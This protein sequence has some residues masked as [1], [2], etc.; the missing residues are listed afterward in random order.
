M[1][2]Q[3]SKPKRLNW[4]L[5]IP[6]G[7]EYDAELLPDHPQFRNKG[8]ILHRLQNSR[9]AVTLAVSIDRKD[10]KRGEELYEE[11][12]AI[13]N[14]KRPTFRQWLLEKGEDAG[15]IADIYKHPVL[16]RYMHKIPSNREVLV[17][18]QVKI[19]N[20]VPTLT[21]GEIHGDLKGTNAGP[22]C[23][24]KVFY[25]MKKRGIPLLVISIGSPELIRRYSRSGFVK[26]SKSK[27]IFQ[28]FLEKKGLAR[29]CDYVIDLTSPLK[30]IKVRRPS[31]IPRHIQKRI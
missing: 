26:V 17:F 28:K 11:W 23:L 2:V 3:R 24:E 6:R 31:G 13:N 1:K 21:Q 19:S 8:A 16:L 25:A 18:T 30:P 20:G 27:P 29:D 22:K 5:T 7:I 12:R 10:P 14:D 4:S 15:S 9:N